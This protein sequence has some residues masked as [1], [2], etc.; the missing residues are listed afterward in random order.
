MLIKIKLLYV[1]IISILSLN[2]GL[3]TMFLFIIYPIVCL[4]I[5]SNYEKEGLIFSAIIWVWIGCLSMDHKLTE[6]DSLGLSIKEVLLKKE[7]EILD[8]Q[9]SLNNNIKNSNNNNINK[10]MKI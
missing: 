1:K 6:I 3:F 7:I 5:S 9:R 2:S 8:E 4:M 10:V